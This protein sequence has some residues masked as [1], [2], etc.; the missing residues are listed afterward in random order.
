VTGSAG[1]VLV[2]RPRAQAPAWVEALVSHGVDAVAVPLI[3][4]GPAPDAAAVRAA[5]QTLGARRLVMFV[6]AS[7]VQAWFAAAPAAVPWPSNVRAAATGPGTVAALRACGVPSEAIDAPADDAPRFDSEALW[8]RLAARDWAGAQVLVV[9]GEGGRDWLGER[10]AERGATLEAVAAYRRTAP[11]L[12]ASERARLHAALDA[13]ADHVWLFGSSEAVAHL[14]TVVHAEAFAAPPPWLA[15]RAVATHARIAES[16]RRIGFGRFFE[17]RA[18][19]PD[20]VACIQSIR[21]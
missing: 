7:A 3:E 6:S 5:W 11:V 19:V 8:A 16:A 4:I 20:V 13:P 12:D 21:P 2:T 1:R 10:L 15:S 14:E 18:T 9:R 17:A